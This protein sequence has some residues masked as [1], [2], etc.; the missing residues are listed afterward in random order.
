MASQGL[1]SRSF[2]K[3]AYGLRASLLPD[4]RALEKQ[5]EAQGR[6]YA[7][8]LK[9][10]LP[11]DRASRLL[12]VPCGHGNLLYC[13][14]SL[15]Y[16]NV[17][18]ADSDPRQ[19]ELAR[20]LGLEAAVADAFS[21]L[22]R[23][24][25]ASVD[26]VFSLDFIEHVP[27]DGAIEFA[28]LAHRALK[29]GGYLLCRTPCADGPFGAADRYNDITHQWALTSTAAHPFMRLA[30]FDANGIEVKQEAPVP[31]KWQNVLRRVLFEVTTQS[32]GRFLELSGI[33][34]PAVW[35]R[36]MWIVARK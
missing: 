7:H 11:G 32:V 26:R 35:T 22:E 24:P 18:G 13:L 27:L 31:Y 12:D 36:S 16:S 5:L 30:G 1:P 8:F 14:K 20:Q 28:K 21:L 2:E 29:P 4:T 23:E 33:G 10:W 9:P 25:V 15:G 17:L 34:A 3:D 6:W 19:V